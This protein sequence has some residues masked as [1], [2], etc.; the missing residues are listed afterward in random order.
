[1]REFMMCRSGNSEKTTQTTVRL[2]EERVKIKP[3]FVSIF[4][5]L[6]FTA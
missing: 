3:I 5:E 1:M 4:N 2:S 6:A